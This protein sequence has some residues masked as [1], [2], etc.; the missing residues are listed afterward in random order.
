M[1]LTGNVLHG[2]SYRNYLLYQE[3][4]ETEIDKA[5]QEACHSA[6]D[7]TAAE[8]IFSKFISTNTTNS[9]PKLGTE[10]HDISMD[11]DLRFKS[12]LCFPLTQRKS[13]I[14]T[15]A[16]SAEPRNKSCTCH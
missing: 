12:D 1:F 11:N 9:N 6:I 7:I 5:V 16:T 13:D 15:A 14:N 10:W 4:L 3:M 2:E 8:K